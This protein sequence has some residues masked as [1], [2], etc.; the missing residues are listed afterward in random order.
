[1]GHPR[2]DASLVGP[3]ASASIHVMA[4]ILEAKKKLRNPQNNHCSRIR[5]AQDL[6][7][8][9]MKPLL[10]KDYTPQN[11]AGWLI[12]EKLDG[13]R[14]LWDGENFLTRQGKILN[15]PEW[16]KTGMP[17][18]QLDGELFAGRRNYNRIQGLMRDAWHGLEFR[19][20]D[21]PD[22][23]R[24]FAER[25]AFA[26]TISLPAHV[27]IIPHRIISGEEEAMAEAA[28]ISSEG[29]EGTVVRCPDAR[30]Q[31]GRS[32]HVLRIV[33]M[34]PELKRI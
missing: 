20:F 5:N 19:V 12:S 34:P 23:P 14:M 3:S 10:L 1:M 2:M 25:I 8:T 17:T 16:V 6:R 26:A 30:W 11:I 4:G 15:A 31:A 28:R 7:M 13:W 24:G 27:S 21:A 9:P 22:F 33:P 29:G 18:Q 32:R